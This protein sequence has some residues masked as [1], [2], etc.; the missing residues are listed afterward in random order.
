[1]KD[2]CY[3]P[4]DKR[5]KDGLEALAADIPVPDVTKAFKRHV[6]RRKQHY[7]IRGIVA[8]A[9]IGVFLVSTMAGPA[10][11]LRIY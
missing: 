11:A 3:N 4:Y 8:A 10:Q 5:I 1:M 7:R 6:H 9:V 2:N